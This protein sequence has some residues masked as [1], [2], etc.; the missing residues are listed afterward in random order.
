MAWPGCV[1]LP[2]IVLSMFLKC[3]RAVPMKARNACADSSS[4]PSSSGIFQAARGSSIRFFA[5]LARA[6][7]A[8]RIAG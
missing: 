8:G 7:R 1:R 4:T 6:M 5:V 3:R 2:A